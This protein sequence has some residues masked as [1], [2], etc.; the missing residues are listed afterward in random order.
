MTP[1]L[2]SL[3]YRELADL[4][5]LA[6]HATGSRWYADPQDEGQWGV[7]AERPATNIAIDCRAG[8]AAHIAR[9]DPETVLAL[10]REIRAWRSRLD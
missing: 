8:D 6:N 10:V 2:G 7:F 5:Y 1:P 3:S 9:A 4:E